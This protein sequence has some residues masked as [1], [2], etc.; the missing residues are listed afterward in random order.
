MSI[1]LSEEQI[2]SVLKGTHIPPQPQIMVDLQMEQAMQNSSLERISELISQ[3][4]GLSGKVL[5]TVN[6]PLYGLSNKITSI[7]QAV[8]L[9]GS[10]SV[11]NLVNALSIRGELSNDDIIALGSFWDNAMEIAMACSTI[12]KQIGYSSPDEAYSLGLFHNCGVPLLTMRFDDYPTIIKESYSRENVTI[13]DV[14][15]ELIQ[16]NH[17]VVGY[18]VA[19]SWNLPSYISVAIHQHH[20]AESVI[21]NDNEDSKKRTLLA[22]LKIAEHICG[23]HRDLGNQD[24]D[25]EWQNIKDSILLYVGLSEYD[26]ESL[27]S[28]LTDMGIGDSS[29]SL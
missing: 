24:V 28:Q 10:D 13:T 9:M 18:Y 19:K 7:N 3:D 22:I 12:A 16:T 14:E 23:N 2:E 26:Y 20:H 4:V 11:I 21:N 15:N 5:K 1:N 17:A 29:L 25:Y 8:N 27:C 6:S